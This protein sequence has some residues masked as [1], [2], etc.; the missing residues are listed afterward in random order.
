MSKI[1][2]KITSEK[3][4]V[5]E[6]IP[7][8]IIPEKEVKEKVDEDYIRQYQFKKVNNIPTIGGVETDPDKGSKAEIMKASL[9]KQNKI[10]MLIPLS[11]G[12][13]PNVKYPVTLNGY[14]LDFPT[15]TYVEVPLQIAEVVRKSNSQTLMALDQHLA[16]ESK[17]DDG[18][19]SRSRAFGV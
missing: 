15:N 8:K 16:S 6:K 7:E 10:S 11:E 5:K 17:G 13:N 3:K 19:K 4:E 18:G 9:L 14:R 1:P 12:S 2:K